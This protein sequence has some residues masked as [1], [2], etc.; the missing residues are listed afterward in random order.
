MLSEKELQG[1]T[2]SGKKQGRT[3]AESKK[4][5]LETV[6]NLTNG[7]GGVVHKDKIR[8]ILSGK[9]DEPEFNKAIEEL[10]AD[11]LLLSTD[12]NV[13]FTLTAK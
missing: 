2:G 13:T 10:V 9:M 11:M 8:S 4:L 3:I 7:G 5:I 6:K 12:N 1:H